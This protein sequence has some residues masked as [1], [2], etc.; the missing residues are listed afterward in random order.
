MPIQ[1]RW[2]NAVLATATQSL[3]QLPWERHGTAPA[4]PPIP[5]VAA[6]R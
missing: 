2:L 4:N 6:Q 3:P 1:R 5:A